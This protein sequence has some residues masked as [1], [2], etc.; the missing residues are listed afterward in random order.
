MKLRE[1]CLERQTDLTDIQKFVDEAWASVDVPKDGSLVI[2]PDFVL[3]NRGELEIFTMEIG[4][5]LSIDTWVQAG[6]VFYIVEWYLT[7]TRL[8]GGESVLE[9]TLVD[10]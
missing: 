9:D 1:F 5:W 2:F 3:L 7:L 6:E 10:T 4:G 8:G